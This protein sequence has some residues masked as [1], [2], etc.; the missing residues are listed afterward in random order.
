MYRRVE[1]FQEKKIIASLKIGV[2]NMSCWL[3]KKSGPETS[4]SENACSSLSRAAKINIFLGSGAELS[5]IKNKLQLRSSSCEE[6]YF[7]RAPELSL[8]KSKK[9]LQL[10]SSGT[11]AKKN[12]AA[13][14]PRLRS[15]NFFSGSGAQAPDLHQLRSPKLRSSIKFHSSGAREPEL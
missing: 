9:K 10:R 7:F 11:R 15:R 8:P 12:F 14:E 3:D 5:K 6:K 2:L 4:C 1:I 13:P